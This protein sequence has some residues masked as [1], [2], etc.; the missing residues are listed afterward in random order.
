DVTIIALLLLF[1]DASLGQDSSSAQLHFFG[2]FSPLCCCIYMKDETEAPEF[3]FYL[4]IQMSTIVMGVDLD[5]DKCSKKIRKAICKVQD[6]ASIR[7]ISYD[8]KTNTVTVTGPFDA[9]EVADRLTSGAGKVITDMH[10]VG[11]GGGGNN[12]KHGAAAAKAPKPGKAKGNGH[13]HDHGHGHGHGKGK[14]KGDKGGKGDGGKPDKKHVK[15]DD[16]DLDDDD[17][18]DFDLHLD[19]P[20]GRHA[21]HG[22]GH[23]HA[24]QGHGH[25]HGHGARERAR[26][27]AQ[28]RHQRPGRGAAGGAAHRRAHAQATPSI[29][30]AAPEWGYSMQPYGSYSG[31]P[32]GGYYG[33]PAAYGAAGHGGAYGYGRNPYGQQYYEEEPSAGCSVM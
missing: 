8:E 13:G 25:G 9:D 11:G 2:F 10:V 27:Q 20:A 26:R 17:D 24:P 33:A 29:W 23:G 28:H 14:G 19:E 7:T 6:K 30:P 18:D 3:A 31:P 5:C 21:P 1:A 16:F 12:H 22:H 15:F 4:Y 32:A